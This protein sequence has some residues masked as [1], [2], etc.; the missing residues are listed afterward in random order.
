MADT[1][2][3]PALAILAAND[4]CFRS[5]TDVLPLTVLRVA[6][7]H[8]TCHLGRITRVISTSKNPWCDMSTLKAPASSG[9]VQSIASAPPALWR[10]YRLHAPCAERAAPAHA[11][12]SRAR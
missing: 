9:L 7:G 4:T 12:A 3:N 1:F 5:E 11:Y 2:V 10:S 6:G 8:T